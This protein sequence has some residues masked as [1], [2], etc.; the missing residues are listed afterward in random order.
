MPLPNMLSLHILRSYDMYTKFA[1]YFSSTAFR[2]NKVIS[3]HDKIIPMALVTAAI[4]THTRM[5]ISLLKR[6]T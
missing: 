2:I 6:E 4:Q 5:K 1:T 3:I